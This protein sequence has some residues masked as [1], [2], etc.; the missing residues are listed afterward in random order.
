MQTPLTIR[1]QLDAWRDQQPNRAN[2]LK[3]AGLDELYRLILTEKGELA[4]KIQRSLSSPRTQKKLLAIGIDVETTWVAMA[5][6]IVDSTK[7]WFPE[8]WTRGDFVELF[9][10]FYQRAGG[11]TQLSRMFFGGK[12][13]E[14]IFKR[15]EHLPS[16]E[17]LVPMLRFLVDDILEDGARKRWNSSTLFFIEGQWNIFGRGKM[18]LPQLTGEEEFN[19]WFCSRV[20]HEGV[21]HIA[22]ELNRALGTDAFSPPLLISWRKGQIPSREKY[23][24]LLRAVQ[25]AFP[26]WLIQGA[27]TEDAQ[28]MPVTAGAVADVPVEAPADSL[29]Q[30]LREIAQALLPSEEETQAQE[31]INRACAH[32]AGRLH[33]LADELERRSLKPAPAAS[34]RPLQAPPMAEEPGEMVDGFRFVLTERTFSRPDIFTLA[35]VEDTEALLVEL[36]RRLAL[37]NSMAPHDKRPVLARLRH[38]FDQ[39][40]LQIRHMDAE[41]PDL[42]AMFLEMRFVAGQLA[43]RGIPTS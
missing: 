34:E 21:D 19:A 26:Q 31:A 5:K 13:I 17:L 15:D 2:A 38:A 16:M 28:A 40:F 32:R 9:R 10:P 24:E 23:E 39:L 1:Q 41:N 27:P 30:I 6:N 8:A 43:G 11:E 18:P 7:D 3:A 35:E 42:P 29:P 20:P 14:S 4:L 25:K 12:Q 36:A 22:K 33:A 37:I